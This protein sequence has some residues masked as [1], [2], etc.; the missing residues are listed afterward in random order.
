M[1]L[2]ERDIREFAAIWKEEFNEELTPD[3]ARHHASELVEL[4]ALLA[5]PLPSERPRDE[6]ASP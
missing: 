6:A 2:N 3:A 4:Y 5:Q 1:D